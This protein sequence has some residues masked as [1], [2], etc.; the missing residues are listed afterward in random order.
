MKRDYEH[1]YKELHNTVVAITSTC[2]ECGASFYDAYIGGKRDGKWL[3]DSC[4]LEF[5]LKQGDKTMKCSRG[6]NCEPLYC[7]EFDNSSVCV[8]NIINFLLKKGWERINDSKKFYNFKPPEKFEFTVDYCLS[9]PKNAKAPDFDRFIEMAT[10]LLSEIYD[11]KFNDL[12]SGGGGFVCVG[13]NDPKDRKIEGDIF[14]KCW[15]TDLI[16][17]FSFNDKDD[18]ILE[19]SVISTALVIYGDITNNKDTENKKI[20]K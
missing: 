5:D 12:L 10:R 16:D 3:C 9:I 4:T 17:E 13:L 19:M 14:C 7:I 15:K 6:K 20:G 1:I 11:T 8:E 2:E 18:F